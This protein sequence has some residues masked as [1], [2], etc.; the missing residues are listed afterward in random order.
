MRC[1]PDHHLNRLELPSASPR[2]VQLNGAMESRGAIVGVAIALVALGVSCHDDRPGFVRMG[3]EGGLFLFDGAQVSL[4]IGALDRPLV[5]PASFTLCPAPVPGFVCVGGELELA[6]PPEISLR[7]PA[8]VRI[9]T[10]SGSLLGTPSSSLRVIELERMEEVVPTD[11]AED[12]VWFSIT[13][14]G[15]YAVFRRLGEGEP[16]CVA[17]A[18]LSDLVSSSSVA[19]AS[20]VSAF[21]GELAS[22]GR[23]ICYLSKVGLR[24]IGF[25]FAALDA[26][27]PPVIAFGDAIGRGLFHESLALWRGECTVGAENEGFR[28]DPARG[29]IS[30]S[31][32]GAQDILAYVLLAEQWG[33]IT[34]LLGRVDGRV[35]HQWPQSFLPEASASGPRAPRVRAAGALLAFS[36]R[37]TTVVDGSDRVVASSTI[38]GKVEPRL[39]SEFIVTDGWSLTRLRPHVANSTRPELG[40]IGRLAIDPQGRIWAARPDA[41]MLVSLKDFEAPAELV[42]VDLPAGRPAAARVIVGIVATPDGLVMENA[43]GDFLVLRLK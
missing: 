2:R 42:V 24:S 16:E 21:P 3:P 35:V 27:P 4:P 25:T 43:A 41:P 36:L 1:D 30:D 20:A 28:T 31:T 8:K 10:N 29:F 37:Q 23:R 5:F 34:P 7:A 11:Y 40:P 33:L 13:R 39:G 22:D 15:R 14:F 19:A 17:C 32:P 12:A 6:G 9:P 18:S 38:A 26:S